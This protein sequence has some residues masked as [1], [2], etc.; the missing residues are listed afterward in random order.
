MKRMSGTLGH[1]I[2]TEEKFHAWYSRKENH[3]RNEM[4]NGRNRKEWN[5]EV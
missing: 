2:V 4:R 3:K 1:E 5:R